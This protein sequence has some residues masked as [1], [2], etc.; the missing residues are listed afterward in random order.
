VIPV[1]VGLIGAGPWAH[2]MHAP[3]LA[4]GPE[5]RLA[6]VWARRADAASA[7]AH[8]F[9]AR[10]CASV[11]ELFDSCEAVAFAVPP[12][13]QADLAPA[14]ARAGKA[15]LLEK[16][17]GL[18]LDQARRVADEVSGVPTQLVLTRRYHPAYRDFI[19]RAR[20][21][22]VTGARAWHLHG[23]LLGGAYATPWRREHGVLLDLGPHSL[24][25]LEAVAGPVTA[26]R[27][28][29]DPRR[30]VEVTCEHASGAVSSA[31]LSG[32]VGQPLSRLSCYGS[33]AALDFDGTGLDHA[34]AWAV[35]RREFAATVRT[36]RPH[37][38]DVRRGLH[39]QELIA[40]ALRR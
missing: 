9:G 5:T 21:V 28:T 35:L 27:A 8:E 24:D 23:A 2:D 19:E 33:R 20:A 34:P 14:A 3:V 29:G 36:G 39:L 16:P 31:A 30:W 17:V 10:A 18:T 6:A 25:L 11:E 22:E 15:L 40:A 13:V 1:E 37:E 4:A 32:S 26:I 7:L 38:L 12:D